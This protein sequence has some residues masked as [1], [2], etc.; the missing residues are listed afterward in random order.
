[1]AKVLCPYF[2]GG[3][4]GDEGHAAHGF[5]HGGASLRLL[6]LHQAHDTHN[7]KTKRW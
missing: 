4:D 5:F 2:R 1:M 7:L 3:E 6:A